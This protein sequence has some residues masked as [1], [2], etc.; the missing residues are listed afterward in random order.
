MPAIDASADQT[1]EPQS[2]DFEPEPTA[3][4]RALTREDL[5]RPKWLAAHVGIVLLMVAFVLL[6]R[7]QWHAGHRV[8]PL[9]DTQLAAWRTP[10]PLDSVITPADGLNG[11]QAGQAVETS[12]RYD[13]TRQLLVPGRVLDGRQGY[14]VLTP[15]ITG[16][17]HDVVVNRGWLPADGSAAPAIPAPPAGQISVVGWAAEPE[18]TTGDVNDN[19]I[20][21]AEPSA[22]ANGPN[23]VSVIAPANLANTWPYPLLNGYLSA[24]DSRSTSGGLT[25][26]PAPL[27]AHGTSWDLLNVGYAFQWCVFAV[28]AGV[29]YVVYWRRELNGPRIADPDLDPD[30]DS[31]LDSDLDLDEAPEPGPDADPLTESADVPARRRIEA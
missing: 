17:A 25:A 15:L 13:P 4:D 10:Q 5:V 1:A 27:P 26:V 6:G 28:I 30:L 20:V 14:Y 22:P 2:A 16:G 21:Q 9:T 8:Q 19:G 7:W 29:W 18:S 12:G 24:T 3:R 31:D 11:T 23:Q